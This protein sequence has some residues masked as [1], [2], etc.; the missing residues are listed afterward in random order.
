MPEVISG[1]SKGEIR[2]AAFKRC[3][4]RLPHFN[5]YRPGVLRR[6]RI[7]LWSNGCGGRRLF[8]LVEFLAEVLKHVGSTLKRI[9]R[10][11]G[12]LHGLNFGPHIGFV[13]RQFAGELRHLRG[14]HTANGENNR[15][16]QEDDAD[17]S[18][19]ARYSEVLESTYQRS[20]Y[21]AEQN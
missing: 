12:S 14:D 21:K 10:R 9:V 3:R 7:C 8:R 1:W 5:G 17:H 16:C 4:R 2:A 13:A 18:N 11:S 6:H 19:R 20:K 15:K